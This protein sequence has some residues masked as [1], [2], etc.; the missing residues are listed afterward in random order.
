MTTVKEIERA[1]EALPKSDLAV[2]S[3][4]FDKFESEMWDDQIEADERNGRFDELRA[5]A[6]G[7]YVSG[8]VKE[9]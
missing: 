8:L 3:T 6:L 2:L 4:W 1:I 9:I 5:E 7:E